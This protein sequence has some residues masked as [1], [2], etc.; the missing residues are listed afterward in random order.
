VR[1]TNLDRPLYPNGFTKGDLV[2]YYRAVAPVLLPYLR[3]RAVT[4]LRAPS[5]VDARS[6]YQTN[7]PGVPPSGRVAEVRGFRMCIL[8][9]E[10][11]LV[12]AAQM[13]TIEFHPYLVRVG[14]ADPDWLVLDLDPGE[15]A[16]M[17]ECCDVALA[18]RERLQRD[19]AWVKTSGSLGLHVL[20]P[21]SGVTFA[22]TKARA[23]ELADGIPGVVTTQRR[24]ARA[25]KVLVDVL[26]NDPT[27][28]LVAPWSLRA[29]AWP[30]V[31]TP[32]SWTEVEQRGQLFFDWR[33]ALERLPRW[34][35][36][37]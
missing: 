6:W 3:G 8:E 19:D 23:R 24:D 18:L 13:G 27:R 34:T 10:D 12:W 21:V 29:T 17:A 22:E 26:Q 25:G 37:G 15:P 31:S 7:C 9:T 4:L 16:G 30:T 1:L 14:E 33:A 11:D 2:A 32:V 5:G 28:S 36:A 35:R 20:A